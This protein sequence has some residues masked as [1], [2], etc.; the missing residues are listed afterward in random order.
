[1]PHVTD[2][3]SAI[4]VQAH[5]AYISFKSLYI[6]QP[7][8]LNRTHSIKGKFVSASQHHTTL[9]HVR[10]QVKLQRVGMHEIKASV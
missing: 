4:K 1:M 3:R 6:Q 9:T 5:C 2:K 7:Y 8:Q 10:M